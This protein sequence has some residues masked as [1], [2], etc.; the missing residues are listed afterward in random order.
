MTAQ[1]FNFGRKRHISFKVI[2]WHSQ[3]K[4][5]GPRTEKKMEGIMA[6]SGKNL[7]TADG[8]ADAQTLSE[9]RGVEHVCK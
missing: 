8:Q 1:F 2:M 5:H 9:V 7:K 4:S 3:N 6:V